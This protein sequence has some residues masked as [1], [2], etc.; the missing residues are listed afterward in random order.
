MGPEM[1]RRVIGALDLGLRQGE[2]LKL[3][4]KHIDFDTWTI[5]LPREITKAKKDQLA[6]AMTP[7]I[8]RVLEERKS[9]GPEGFIFGKENGRFVASFD[10]TWKKLFKLAGLR[11]GRKG[12]LVWHDLRHEYGSYLADQDVKIHELKALMRHQDIRTTARYLTARDERLRE[13]AGKMGRRTA[14]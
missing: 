3:Q 6:Y 11:V 2:M 10:K 5:Q 14:G 12:G 1:A 9:L 7:R 8:Q 13:L 4:V